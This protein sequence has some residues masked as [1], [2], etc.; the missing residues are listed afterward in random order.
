MVKMR[1]RG[2]SFTENDVLLLQTLSR[3]GTYYL[4]IFDNQVPMDS[5]V[6]WEDETLKY[7]L[8]YAHHMTELVRSGKHPY[9]KTEWLND[10]LEEIQQEIEERQ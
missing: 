2:I 6:R 4:R 8:A 3:L 10:T 1:P 7:Y 9:A 5:P